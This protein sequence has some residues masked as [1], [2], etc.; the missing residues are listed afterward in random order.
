[1]ETHLSYIPPAELKIITEAARIFDNLRRTSVNKNDS[2][3]WTPQE[4]ML[5]DLWAIHL[6]VPGEH[7]LRH[8]DF[9]QLGGDS[10]AERKLSTAARVKGISLSA[11]EIMDNQV[12]HVMATIMKDT[13][14]QPAEKPRPFCLIP[15]NHLQPTLREAAMGYGISQDLIEDIY[16]CTPFQAGWMSLSERHGGKDAG[17]I[18]TV[19]HVDPRADM[20]RLA[21]AWATV[22][23]LNP[24]MRTRLRSF[25]LC[26]HHSIWDEWQ[27]RL[28]LEQVEQVYRGEISSAESTSA[29][30]VFVQY[31]TEIDE[32]KENSYSQN[33]LE[34]DG[35]ALSFPPIT[36]QLSSTWSNRSQR[37]DITF[38]AQV[39]RSGNTEFLLSTCIRQAWALICAAYTG[40]N[41]VVFGATVSG[42]GVPVSGI[43]RIV[44]P[45]VAIVPLRVQ[46]N[47]DATV[48][49]TL[50]GIHEQMLHMIPY[51]QS[52]LQH[53]QNMGPGPTAACNFQ[54]LL[55]VRSTPPV[56]QRNSVL[57]RAEDEPN[58]LPN[59][60]SYPLVVECT[61]MPDQAGVSVRVAYNDPVLD[62]VK[63]ER[64]IEQLQLVLVQTWTH[65]NSR[66]RDIDTVSPRELETLS[67]WNSSMPPSVE[68]CLHNLVQG[69]MEVL[70]DMQAVYSWD[71]SLTARQLNELSSR[72]AGHIRSLR[73]GPE[74]VV[75]LFFE[76]SSLIVVTVLAVLK[77]GNVCLALDKSQPAQRLV[78]MVRRT[79][80]QFMLVSE[81]LD[82]ALQMEDVSQLVVT[83]RCVYC[84]RRRHQIFF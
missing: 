64:I 83:T 63:I 50:K 52:G 25:V 56:I 6:N 44:G 81:S 16:P 59:L 65:P 19:I 75:P 47:R 24:I 12:L 20:A 70:P 76:R 74:T 82:G 4:I 38:D 54:S 57:I 34:D 37:R 68:C 18:R 48:Q 45:T 71:K 80:A 23:Y 55:I 3:P 30:N 26:A 7:V 39:R 46:L 32:A 58:S 72:L 28:V 62:A 42:R 49:E 84:T 14:D 73:I 33:A 17:V 8:D 15:N 2:L 5:R 1:M 11:S 79:G 43:E 36:R 35:R 77:S 21:A 51:E 78:K 69:K 53:I 61:I 60:R 13:L 22:F 41:D 10:I 40:S 31:L 9:S 29:F 67:T 66:L 27:T